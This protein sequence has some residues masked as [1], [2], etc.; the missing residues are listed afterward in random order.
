MP[1]LR[2]VTPNN[3]SH[4][5]KLAFSIAVCLSIAACSNALP[6]SSTDSSGSHQED[7]PWVEAFVQRGYRSDGT[8]EGVVGKTE[9]TYE[10]EENRVVSVYREESHYSTPHCFTDNSTWYWRY[11]DKDE[12]DEYTKEEYGQIG[13]DG[14]RIIETEYS[15]AREYDDEGRVIK[16][17][18][19]A[20]NADGSTSTSV[21]EED[22][23]ENGELRSLVIDG[24]SLINPNSDNNEV[25][26]NSH[27]DKL[28]YYSDD[29]GETHLSHIDICDDDGRIL[30]TIGDSLYTFDEFPSDFD[31]ELSDLSNHPITGYAYDERGNVVET[32]IW[33]DNSIRITHD[34]YANN[35]HLI[36][37]TEYDNYFDDPAGK[38]AEITTYQY[39][40]YKTGEKTELLDPADVSV[41]TTPILVEPLSDYLAHR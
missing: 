41:Q 21:E 30:Y 32:V 5:V 4:V 17:T 35:G 24:E 10:V 36:Y 9:N 19:T 40:N 25:Q 34:C 38:S 7:D 12:H 20:K 27:G 13:D 2:I 31:T 16:C 22:Y 1:R 33:D 15:Y 18:T 11:W 14:S 39:T 37:S 29:S 3:V 6:N 28:Y 26:S 8:Y 23:N